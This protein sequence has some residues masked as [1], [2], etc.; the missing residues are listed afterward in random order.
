[1]GSGSGS[2]SDLIRIIYG[3]GS[4]S[5]FVY[6]IFGSSPDGTV[7]IKP[8]A[9]TWMQMNSSLARRSGSGRVANWVSCFLGL[10]MH[11]RSRVRAPARGQLRVIEYIQRGLRGI[12]NS[13]TS[14]TCQSINNYIFHRSRSTST[15]ISTPSPVQA[16]PSVHIPPSSSKPSHPLPPSVARS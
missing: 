15:T 14:S 8:V 10:G 16:A 4:G 12:N 3:M 7:D 11:L 2:R 9:R 6:Y 1:M 5:V 13:Y